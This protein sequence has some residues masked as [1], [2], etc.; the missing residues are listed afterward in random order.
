MPGGR[1]RHSAYYSVVADEWPAVRAR[2]ET[3]LGSAGRAEGSDGT[4]ATRG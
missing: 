2:L 1:L 3:S 4:A